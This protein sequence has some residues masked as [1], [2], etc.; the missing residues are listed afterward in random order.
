MQPYLYIYIYNA[1]FESIGLNYV[2]SALDHKEIILQKNIYMYSKT[3][4][5]QPL[6]KDKTKVLMTNGSLMKVKSIAECSHWSILQ[7]V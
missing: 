2:M 5:K 1:V 6:K 7:Y 3:C 4:V